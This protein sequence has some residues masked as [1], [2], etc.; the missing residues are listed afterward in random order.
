MLI[1]GGLLLLGALVNAV[2]IQNQAA[3]PTS[4]TEN[5]RAE[6]ASA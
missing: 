3:K 1:G 4:T 2:G 6:P 5:A